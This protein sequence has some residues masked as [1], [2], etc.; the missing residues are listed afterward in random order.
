MPVPPPV[1][2]ACSAV[3]RRHHTRSVA[4]LGALRQAMQLVAAGQI[5]LGPGLAGVAEL[6]RGMQRPV[7]I[8][9]VRPREAAQVGAPRHQ[10]RVDVVGL[11]DVADR[12]G[13]DAGLVADAVGE[14]RLEHAP[15]DGPALPARSGPPTRR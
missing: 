9:E 12:H 2:R 3:E 8:G 13:G 4:A 15:V 10:D 7:G 14:R 6:R 1:I 11:V 5:R